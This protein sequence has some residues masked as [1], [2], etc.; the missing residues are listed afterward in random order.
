M[1]SLHGKYKVNIQQEYLRDIF[2]AFETKL[3][4]KCIPSDGNPA[5]FPRKRDSV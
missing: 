5:P 4:W 2:V 3:I 1:V